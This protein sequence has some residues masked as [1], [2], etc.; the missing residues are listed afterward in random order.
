MREADAVRA[1]SVRCVIAER[2]IFADVT[3]DVPVTELLGRD[4][5]T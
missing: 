5:Q 4:A 2:E 3:F 1:E